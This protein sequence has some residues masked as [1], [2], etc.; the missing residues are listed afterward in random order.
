MAL[1]YSPKSK[2]LSLIEMCSWEL[3]RLRA[4]ASDYRAYNSACRASLVKAAALLDG[5]NVAG[6]DVPLLPA[7]AEDQPSTA[8]RICRDRAEGHRIFAGRA[9]DPLI[10]KLLL[11]IAQGYDR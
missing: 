8:I 2:S 9:S 7:M 5:G 10:R 1:Q 4:V 11:E 6:R 3:D